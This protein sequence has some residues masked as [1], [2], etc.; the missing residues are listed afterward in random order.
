ME[1]SAPRFYPKHFMIRFTALLILLVFGL[2]A[3]AQHARHKMPPRKKHLVQRSSGGSRVLHIDPAQ[4][5]DEWPQ[6]Q[7]DSIEKTAPFRCF[8]EDRPVFPGDLNKFIDSNLHYPDSAKARDEQGR[9]IVQF[10]VR[11]NG[12]VTDACILRSA[13]KAF[14]EEALRVINLMPR[15]IPAGQAGH[16]VDVYYTMPV[17]FMLE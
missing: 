2:S 17:T 15:W 13:G 12:V 7:P 16:A 1:M 4:A 9:V 11:K 5:L 6:R 3:F 10:I 8:L 14:D